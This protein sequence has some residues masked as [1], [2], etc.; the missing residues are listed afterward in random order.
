MSR[1]LRVIVYGR[2][3]KDGG[4]PFFWLGDTD[5]ELFAK[6]N[7]AETDELLPSRPRLHRHSAG[8]LREGSALARLE[9]PIATALP[10]PRL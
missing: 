7:C 2:F 4:S 10:Q 6:L 3:L 8:W 5:W 1:A 9:V